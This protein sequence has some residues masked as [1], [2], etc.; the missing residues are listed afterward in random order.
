MLPSELARAYKMQ[1]DAYKEAGKKQ[2][3]LKEIQEAS[4]PCGD[5]DSGV[6][7]QSEILGISLEK[8]AVDNETNDTKIYR[9]IRLNYLI[10]RLLNM[11]DDGT[12]GVIPAVSLSFLKEDEQGGVLACMEAHGFKIDVAKAN[13]LHSYSK[14]GSMTS[15]RIYTVLSGAKK[16]PGRPVQI[17]VNPKVISRFFTQGQTPAE[18]NETIEKALEIYLSERGRA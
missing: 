12:I 16:K 7:F 15:E 17:K 11:V 1:L 8:V 2:K 3:R 4:N 6:L 9:Y 13:A 5:R 14:A 18:I 10:E